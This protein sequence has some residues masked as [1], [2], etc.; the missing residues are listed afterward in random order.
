MSMV[1][2]QGFNLE[3]LGKSGEHNSLHKKS[4]P[5]QAFD[6]KTLQKVWT[7]TKLDV[8]HLR[9]FGRKT[10]AHILDERRS[11]LESK[12]IPCVFLGYWEGTKT[13]RL[14]CIESKRIIKS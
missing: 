12:S 8:S 14:M 11:E 9:V 2:A 4:M 1:C 10:Y 3:I 7:G 6:S 5:N 13:Y